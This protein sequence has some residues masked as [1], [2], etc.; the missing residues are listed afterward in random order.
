M[1]KVAF[2]AAFVV[3]FRLVPAASA[4]S[5][6]ELVGAWRFVSNVN[7]SSSGQESLPFGMNPLGVAI[8][9]ADGRFALMNLRAD[10]P[11]IASSNRMQATPAEEKAIV[12]GA[13]A[14]HGTYTLD[15]KDLSLHVEGSSFANWTG[16]DQKRPIVKWSPAEF[17]WEVAS[18]VGGKSQVTWQKLH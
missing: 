1:L 6:S 8:F 2:F 4:Q 16:T 12:Q 13:L 17:T 11:K 9:T 18:S 10:L 14:L 7:T 5:V 3:A 15:G